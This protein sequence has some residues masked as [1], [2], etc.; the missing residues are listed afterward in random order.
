MKAPAKVKKVKKS[1]AK[2]LTKS[3]S[4]PFPI[5]AIGAS[6]GGLEAISEL[7][8]YLS[9][10]TGM[11]FIYV[12]HLSPDH[13]SL[14]TALLAKVTTMKVQDVKDKILI[15]P[16]NVYVIPPDKEI[17]VTNGHIKLSPRPDL[18]K[19][20][21][22]IDLLF[23]SL[24][25]THKE[26]V[27]GVIL[28]GSA[29]DG[30]QGMKSIK[31]EGGLTFAQ[32]SSAKFSSMPKS[33]IAAGVVDY[34]LSPKEIALELARISRHPFVKAN[35]LK[36]G[37]EDLIE[38]S[39]PDLKI[40]LNCLYKSTHVDFSAYKM[41]T[42]KRRIMR[43][44]L[45]H[46]QK[47]LKEYAKLLRE[48]Q[49]EQDIL[50]QDLLINVTSFFRDTDTYKYL[51][52]TL[53]PKLLK[54]KKPG[55]T[56]RIW[57]PACS[58]G[59]EAFSIAMMLLEIQ[60]SKFSN[61]P[62]QI[63][64]S[65]LSTRAIHKA[66][67]GLYSK[68][69]LEAVS[70]RRAQRFFS[71]SDGGFRIDKA[72]RNICVFAPHNI[73]LD[74][75]FSRIDFISCRN[76][77]IYL[78]TPAQKR[79][80]A[81]F[82]YALRDNGYLM[83]GKSETISS[84]AHLYKEINKKFK[85]FSR[86]SYSGLR[87]LP[88]VSPRFTNPD[89]H[90][91]ETVSK[92]ETLTRVKHPLVNRGLDSAIDA[93]LIADHM[94]AS[95][96]INHQM[97]IV[98]FR[99]STD[100][101]L[102]NAAG[103]ATF[104]ILRMA[105]PE[106]AFSMRNSITKAIKSNH[107]IVKTG[108]ETRVNNTVRLVGIEVIPLT[109]KSDEPLL[110]ILFT[111]Q[112][113]AITVLKER[114]NGKP[115]S[116][117]KDRR[118]K[119]LQE[120]LVAAHAE[121]LSFSQEQE[122]FI[123][124]LQSANEEV[125]SSNE[126]LQTVNEELETSK[127][128]ME[129]T[130]EELI[131]TNEELQTR[132]DLLIESYDY[133][134][135]IISTL[136]EPMLIL[137]NNL[138]VKT[139]NEAFYKKFDV[140]QEETEG[141]LLYE[142]GNKQWDIPR[143]RE[144]LEDIVPKNSYFRDFE[145]TH[146]FPDIGEKVLMLNARRIVQKS[147]GEQLILLSINDITAAVKLQKKEKEEMTRDMRITKSYNVKLEEAVKQRTSELDRINSS[148]AE[149][150]TEL[151]KMVKELEAFAYVSSHDLQE[152]LRKIRTFAGR[153]LE[154]ENP[155]LSDTGKNYFRL[156]QNSAERMQALIKDLL[157]FSRISTAERKFETLDITQLVEE[158]KEEFKDRIE[159]TKAVV[160]LQGGGKINVIPFQFRQVL[161]NLI[162]NAL[163]F[164]KPG[165]PPHIIIESLTVES[166]KV[167]FVKLMPKKQ[168][169]QISIRDNGIGFEPEYTDKIFKVFE[170]LHSKDEYA[171]TGIGLAIVKK[172]VD[173]HNGFINAKSEPSKGTTFDIFIPTT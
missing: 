21:L 49:E 71:K 42:I 15:E 145:V 69:E 82:H 32:D 128:E 98:Q 24:A 28:S 106:I 40:I 85:I 172:I 130:N 27:I 150:N 83:L 11:A 168:Y 115:K 136:H 64:A 33:A 129:S 127:E 67:I 54:D 123:E 46:K 8:K 91:D 53:L 63:F 68:H 122:A 111:E 133:S 117:V 137:D 16:N 125:V 149:K 75:P 37:S 65:D 163:K 135:A 139:A 105:R 131:T 151:E 169:N 109:I 103:K 146:T 47:G 29:S 170:K 76:L 119:Q 143:L 156:M 50:Y 100:L 38:N 55:E 121:S 89:I 26:N 144:L 25:A 60:D 23:S 87:I 132:N 116:D 90:T 62:V 165:V 164:A 19:I 110:L 155:N 9:P 134:T 126:E 81:T 101:Y 173:N 48:K 14:L 107:R 79:A 70:P 78:D 166:N 20:N 120:E 4:Y 88:S 138:R 152:P 112:P 3:H 72:V 57:V 10:V 30:T 7:L 114:K 31:H 153:I 97:E 84:S 171:G 59:E 6:A 66:R 99:G 141:I 140:N 102:T 113:V 52:T 142:L 35:L 93:L 148:L 73:L 18:P 1:Q 162:S 92:A 167:D 13:K 22:P 12:Q 108:I 51:K 77:F 118:I 34:I 160:E 58:T 86:K 39:D 159:E 96:V 5:V 154:K 56:L 36:T 44:M 157:A 43:R 45:L 161:Q 147:H 94:P 158:V 74:P 80:L 95:V 17:Q 124:E 2:R 61:I 104:N 41:K